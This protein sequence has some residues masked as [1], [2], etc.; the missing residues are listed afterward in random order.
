MKFHVFRNGEPVL[1]NFESSAQA[2][3]AAKRLLSTKSSIFKSSHSS[4][5]AQMMHLAAP[6]LA[7]RWNQT[8][9]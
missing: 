8:I 5:R 7:A 6:I 3:L 4:I 1:M 9:R 2:K